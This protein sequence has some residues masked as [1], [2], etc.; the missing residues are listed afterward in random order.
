M[1]KMLPLLAVL[2]A[3]SLTCSNLS[4]ILPTAS[5]NLA[6]L[7]PSM[8]PKDITNQTLVANTMQA[9]LTQVAAPPQQATATPSAA[10]E[11]GENAPDL[12]PGANTGIL[13]NTGECFNFDTG[14]VT[15]PD[16]Q[17][18]VSLAQP[19]LFH[20]LNGAQISG[21]VTLSAPSRSYC[22]SARYEPGDLA[23]QTDLF[24][25]FITNQSQVG[26]VV[27]RSYRGDI[28]YTGVVFD[29]WIFQ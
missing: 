21:Y 13:L 7:T 28:P 1:K 5:P 18:D 6:V 20:Q 23:V 3:F 27:V 14:Q 4:S 9:V 2:T 15:S 11:P 29:Y 12:L 26:F 19:M 24:M 25:C 10:P 8:A 17:C 16:S 22:A